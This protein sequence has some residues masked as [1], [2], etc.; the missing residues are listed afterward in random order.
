MNAWVNAKVGDVMVFPCVDDLTGHIRKMKV[1]KRVGNTVTVMDLVTIPKGS[2]TDDPIQSGSIQE[3][4]IDKFWS[5]GWTLDESSKVQNLLE[6][7][8]TD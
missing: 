8:E 5:T 2:Y 6:R 3:T 4:N 7:Y 1:L